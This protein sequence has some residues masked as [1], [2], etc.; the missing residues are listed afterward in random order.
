MGVPNIHKLEMNKK[1][2]HTILQYPYINQ[3]GG[4]PQFCTIVNKDTW[5]S[6]EK[7]SV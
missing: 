6:R 1:Q 7:Q 3:N 5:Y 2:K 4:T